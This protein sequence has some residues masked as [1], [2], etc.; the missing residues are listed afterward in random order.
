MRKYEAIDFKDI[1]EVKRDFTYWNGWGPP[2][3]IIQ[4]REYCKRNTY[5]LK[6]SEN[7]YRILNEWMEAEF[8]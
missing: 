5:N 7:A 8:C 6:E 3:S 2:A 4:I 1:K